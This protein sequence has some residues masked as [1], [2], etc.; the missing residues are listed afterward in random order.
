M[1]HSSENTKTNAK[2]FSKKILTVTNFLLI[3]K[4][5]SIYIDSNNNNESMQ[6]I[7]S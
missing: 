3:G 5:S 4:K 7:I 2:K 6:R 1:C